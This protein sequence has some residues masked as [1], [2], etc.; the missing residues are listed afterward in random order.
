MGADAAAPA[1]LE[2][3]ALHGAGA[4]HCEGAE[5]A[6]DAAPAGGTAVR[7]AGEDRQH[8]RGRSGWVLAAPLA[9]GAGGREPCGGPGLDPWTAAQAE[10]EDRP[11]R[12]GEVGAQPGL[13]AGW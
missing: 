3:V 6:D 1:Q 9:G 5:P 13:L 8:L 7:P 4:R 12:W 2:A 10:R 11:D